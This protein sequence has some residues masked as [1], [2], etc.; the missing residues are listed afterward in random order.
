MSGISSLWDR[1]VALFALSLLL[2]AI[3]WRSALF[4]GSSSLVE[5]GAVTL[6]GFSLRGL[7]TIQAPL[8]SPTVK[9]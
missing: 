3:G 7:V 2:L 9:P 8:A 5:G 6:F 4:D 1:D